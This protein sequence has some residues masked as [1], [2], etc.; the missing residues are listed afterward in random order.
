MIQALRLSLLSI[1]SSWL[2]GIFRG[3]LEGYHG[4][5]V[6]HVLHRFM[7]EHLAPRWRAI[8]RGCRTFWTQDLPS[9][10]RV[11]VGRARGLKLP[12]LSR[13][14]YFLVLHDVSKLGLQFPLPQIGA[15]LATCFLPCCGTASQHKFFS[16]SC[17]EFDCSD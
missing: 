16:P 12:G 17:P 6:N 8:W 1:V 11:T 4:I 15:V 9:R 14:F 2:P 13:T 10:H 7:F 5:T 3:R